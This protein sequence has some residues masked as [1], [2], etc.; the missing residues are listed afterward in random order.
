MATTPAMTVMDLEYADDTALIA[1]TTEI[2]TRLLRATEAEAAKY[3]LKLNRTKTCRLAYNTDEPVKF[4][5]GAEVPRVTDALYLGTTMND[6]GD[7]APE[8]GMR[9]SRGMGVCRALK[10]LWGTS[11]L[12]QKLAL[13]VLRSCVFSALTYGLHTIFMTPVQERKLDAAQ[14]RFVRW[15]TRTRA[16]YGAKLIGTEAVTNRQLA[17]KTGQKP[18]SKEVE[19]SRYRLLGHV[20]RRDGADTMR[21]VTYDRFGQPKVLSGGARI[22]VARK[23]WAV[24]VMKGATDILRSQ[25]RLSRAGAAPTGHEYAQVTA[26][27]QH[28][29][30]WSSW[31]DQWFRELDWRDFT[32]RSS[33]E[34][35]M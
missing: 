34:P 28:R 33:L 16:T 18:L 26:L 35:Q 7:P 11:T 2:A 22:G 12:G 1:R 15:A 19:R 10:P 32:D 17:E 20:L 6:R 4:A 13:R 5:D 23:S 9:I 30:A 31:V 14:M 3:G 21:A 24:E 27:A 25:G 8:I 29:E